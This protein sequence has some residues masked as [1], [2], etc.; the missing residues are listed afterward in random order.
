MQELKRLLLEAGC[1]GKIK[2]ID[3]ILPSVDEWDDLAF[4]WMEKGQKKR[5]NSSGN[6]TSRP[7]KRQRK[8][9]FIR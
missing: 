1:F 2:R 9:S 6:R 8:E 7:Q 3:C 5:S 4:E